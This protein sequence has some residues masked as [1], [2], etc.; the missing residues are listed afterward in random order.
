M[1]IRVLGQLSARIRSA[2][3]LPSAGKPR[4]I[5]AL[6]A[7]NAGHV[8]TV[9]TLMEEIWGENVPRSAATT[10]QTYILQLRRRIGAAL[11]SDPDRDAK[12]VLM[13]RHGGYLLET[14]PG[15]LDADEFG[16]LAA[17]GNAAFEAHDYQ[18][19]STL[20][21]RAL[22]LWSGPALVD[23]PVGRVLELEVLRL[24]EIRM[25]ALEWRIEAE[26]AL[27]RHT[28]LL[29]ELRV[30]V[31]EHPMNENLCALLM[32]A[33]YRSGHAWRALETYQRLRSTLVEELGIEP[34]QRLRSLHQEVLSNK[35]DLELPVRG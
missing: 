30:L 35:A 5:L 2:S 12:D 24:T 22:C 11:S 14:Q 20:L 28:D 8:V 32:V 27:R 7:L 6:L 26:L 3:I 25:R 4:Q 1:D 9:P 10:L 18:G 13:T 23:V 17:A 31:A 34:S 33:L 15:R 16:R 29:A 19:A 21:G